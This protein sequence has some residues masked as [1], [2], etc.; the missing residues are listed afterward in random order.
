MSTDRLVAIL[1]Y[2]TLPGWI[3]G[4]MIHQRNRS[5][6]GAFHLRQSLGIHVLGLLLFFVR[7]LFLQIPFGAPV[8]ALVDLCWAALFLCL[9]QGIVHAYRGRERPLPLVGEFIQEYFRSI[10]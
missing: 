9:V 8:R 1:G 5:G 2:C 4:F 3:L 10:A 6:L 7:I